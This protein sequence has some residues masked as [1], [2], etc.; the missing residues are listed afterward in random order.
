MMQ[1]EDRAISVFGMYSCKELTEV[2]PQ[3]SVIGLKK[4]ACDW[5]LSG[6]E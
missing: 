4:V 6:G 2:P 3:N 5:L 1:V